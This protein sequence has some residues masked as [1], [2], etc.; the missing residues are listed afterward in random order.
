M[1]HKVARNVFS[2]AVSKFV[3]IFLVLVGYAAV[4]RY[5]GVYRFGQYQFVLSYVTLFSVVVDFGIQQLVIKKISEQK[6]LGKKYLGN[7]FAIEVILAFFVYMILALVAIVNHY[8]PIVRDAIFLAGLGMF[9]NAITIPFT[10]VISAY[11]D[12]HILAVVNFLD[13]VINV[14]VMFYTI[15]TRGSIIP[16]ASV[17]LL[18]GIMHLI[19]YRRV[20]RKYVPKPELFKHLRE[21]DFSLVKNMLR[22]ALPFG[23]LVGFSAIYNRIDVIIL[24]HLKGYAETGLYTNAYKFMDLLAFFPA[25]VSSSLYPFISAESFQTNFASLKPALENYTRYMIAL[26]APIALGGVVLAPKL[27]LL[28]G[29][30]QFYP[31]FKALQIIVFASAVLFIYS[32]V[33]S[34]MISQMTRRAGLITLANIFINSIGN[35]LL[36]PHFGFVAAAVMT[37]VSELIQASLYFYFVQ[38]RVVA[39]PVWKHFIK[40]VFCALIMALLLWKI[41]FFSLALTLPLGILI[42]A[43][44][45]FATGFLKKKD[46]LTIRTL[47]ANRN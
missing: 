31:A 47:Y 4:S 26:A 20:I 27:I 25:V 11:E 10:A 32:A 16:L 6:E 18:M 37:L 30:A 36:I 9:L 1:S 45:I 38:T 28:I 2:L 34:V 43:G 12:M 3:A 24:A 7:F 23:M 44:L 19:V 35:F 41:R 42:Y 5:L 40:P 13:S 46:L 17:T 29:G 21:L 8:D 33:N 39:F 14:G 22:L 15:I